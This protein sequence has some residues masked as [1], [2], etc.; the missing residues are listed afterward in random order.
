M[1]RARRQSAKASFE[2]A[3]PIEVKRAALELAAV[4]TLAEQET[5][6]QQAEYL[7]GLSDKQREVIDHPA[8]VKTVRTGRRG[9]KTHLLAL[10][11]IH[12]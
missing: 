6:A 12:I 9:G 7:A 4:I 8:K 5:L 3:Y 2:E 1:A 11:L 10:S